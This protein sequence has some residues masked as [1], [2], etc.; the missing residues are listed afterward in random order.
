MCNDALTEDRLA[1]L[2]QVF[3]ELMGAEQQRYA[4]EFE[5]VKKRHHENIMQLY[6]EYRTNAGKALGTN[7]GQAFKQV[8]E[9]K[10]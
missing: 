4:Q 10:A 8:I 9:P 1:R 3:F 7:D 6:R 2:R 5:E